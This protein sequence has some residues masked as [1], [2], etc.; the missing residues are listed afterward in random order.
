MKPPALVAVLFFAAT[1]TTVIYT[2]SLHDALPIWIRVQDHYG[3][4]RIAGRY[5]ARDEG[6]LQWRGIVLRTLLQMLGGCR[7][8]SAW[9]GGHLESD[10]SILRCL[11]LYAGG[12]VRN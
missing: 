5:C 2:L 3:D 12:K 4:C 1:A 7:T 10:L 9:R 11:L 8:S 6:N